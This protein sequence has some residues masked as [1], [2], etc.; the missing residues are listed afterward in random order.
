MS[1]LILKLDHPHSLQ[2]SLE[3]LKIQ[4]LVSSISPLSFIKLLKEADNKVNP[5]I[6]TVN[7]ITKSIL[8][9]LEFSPELFWFKS[10][11]ILLATETCE[12]LERN[13]VRISLGNLDY[14]GI[15]DGGHN[16]FAVAIYLI[17]QLFDV[18]IK[19][20][21]SCKEFWNENYEEILTRYESRKDEFKFSIPIEIIT[22]NSED[23][24]VDEFYDF[25]SE[26]CSARNNNVQLK[27]TAKGNQVGFYDYLK[28]NL[29]EEFEI[30][31]K[32]GDAGKIKSED[33]ISLSTLG[34]IF[35]KGKGVLPEEINGLNKVSIYSQKGKCVDFFNEVMKNKKISVEEKGK[36]QL[37]SKAVKSVLDLTSDILRFFD[38]LYI[39]FPNLYH[40]A[41]PGKFGRISSVDNKK[42][43][44][45]P[46]HTTDETSDYQYSPGFFY[47]LICGLTNLMK[48]DEVNDAVI[49]KTNPV[50]LDLSKLELSQYVELIRMVNYDPQKIGK[51]SAFYT[52]AESVFERLN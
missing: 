40:Q 19:D 37:R 41:A 31:W 39:E 27:E 12:L 8:E 42:S 25:I 51:G 33:V 4:K 9:T 14:E 15:M 2:A 44:K 30:I 10:K 13:R 45:V 28:G 16:T 7:P 36:Y 23:G 29:D 11:G 18:K 47:P 17:E 22:P 52:E 6:A 24:A 34:L 1:S 3:G 46:F 38:R 50:D 35:L 20:W 43:G 49:W 21:V 5:R 26:I 48:Y 32:T